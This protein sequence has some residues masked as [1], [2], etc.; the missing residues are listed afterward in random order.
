MSDTKRKE[1]SLALQALRSLATWFDRQKRVLPW[2]DEPTLYH[3]WISE[4]MLQQT[5]VITVLP[6]FQKFIRRFP[7]VESLAKASLDDVLLHWAGLG[8]YSRARN[9][10]KGAQMIVAAR[11]AAGGAGKKNSGFPKTREGWLEIPG[12]GNYTAGAILSIALDQPEAILDGNVERVLSRVRRVSRARGDTVF[13]SRLWTLSRA[14]V[15]R[16]FDLG[17]A[18]SVTNQALMELGATVCTPRKPMCMLCPVST[19]CQAFRQGDVENFPPK[20]KPK[21]W[22][23]V[24]EQ[25]HCLMDSEGRVLL[26][27]R[28]KGEWRAGLW[29]LLDDLSPRF[30]SKDYEKIGFVD[31]KHVVTRHKIQRTTHVWKLKKVP[32]EKLQL[33]P[34]FCWTRVSEDSIAMGSAL[35]RTLQMVSERYPEM[36]G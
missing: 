32:G 20:K 36:M 2:R 4:I 19:V 18:P 15:T 16:A 11:G 6:Y 1:T 29:D 17:I 3:V 7:T 34:G 24:Q 30:T 21:E 10:H 5:Q 8:Y 9:I 12:V 28:E 22:I 33:G 31:S 25:L 13:R 35:K 14:T 23:K 27:K 26:R